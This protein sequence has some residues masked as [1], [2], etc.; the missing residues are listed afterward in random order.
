MSYRDIHIPPLIDPTGAFMPA[1]LRVILVGPT[2]DP[3][4][5]VRVPELDMLAGGMSFDV[6]EEGL[7]IALV[8][9]DQIAPASHYYFELATAIAASRLH[10]QIP[11]GDSA[12]PWPQ[13]LVMAGAILDAP[14]VPPYE[15]PGDM[16]QLIYDPHG[17]YT[18]CFDA[19][20]LSGNF[21]GGT[22][23]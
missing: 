5:G 18:D 10:V 8:P 23:N 16:Q 4:I 13:L 22:F 21:D 1:T 15:V 20:N 2:M 3:L 19:G 17:K 6:S 12:L 9:S 14:G 11:T 7:T